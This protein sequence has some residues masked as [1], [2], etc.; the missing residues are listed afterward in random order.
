VCGCTNDNDH[1]PCEKKNGELCHWVSEDLCSA[2]ADDNWEDN[3]PADADEDENL[4]LDEITEEEED[5]F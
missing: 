5:I 2:C 1:I 3:Y 4:I